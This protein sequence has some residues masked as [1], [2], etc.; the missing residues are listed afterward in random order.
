[1][2]NNKIVK[3]LMK[4]KRVMKYISNISFG[5]GAALGAYALYTIFIVNA[6]LPPNVCP[7]DNGRPV[8]IVAVVFLAISLVVS[9]SSKIL[10]LHRR[11]KGLE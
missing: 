2:K 10:G 5:I 6:N 7:I 1:M 8:L 4:H 11:R 3:Y 9:D